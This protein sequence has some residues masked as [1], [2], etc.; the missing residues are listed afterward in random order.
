MNERQK[1]RRK[2][3]CVVTDQNSDWKENR[4]LTQGS[5]NMYALQR[6]LT[7]VKSALKITGKQEKGKM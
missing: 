5:K 3:C 6:M 1:T 4:A 7:A 2:L